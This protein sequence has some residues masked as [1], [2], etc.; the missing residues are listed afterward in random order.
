MSF[1][2]FASGTIG[3]H[4]SRR[5]LDFGDVYDLADAISGAASPPRSL[6]EAAEGEVT[7][8]LTPQSAFRQFLDAEGMLVGT[9]LFRD[10]VTI[11]AA[12]MTPL[13]ITVHC[14]QSNLIMPDESRC[15]I[16]IIEARDSRPDW[17]LLRSL[18]PHLEATGMN[19]FGVLSAIAAALA[20][21]GLVAARGSDRMYRLL[22]Q[23]SA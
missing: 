7:D 20:N 11:A 16:H 12:T 6:R 9:H 4:Y 2:I 13:H 17:D 19:N 18:T 15:C 22:I 5:G 10:A 1:E 3:F 23:L 21:Y 8:R 14:R